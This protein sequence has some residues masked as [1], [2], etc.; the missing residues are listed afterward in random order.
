MINDD[1]LELSEK[2]FD[3]EKIRIIEKIVSRVN[4]AEKDFALNEL[5]EFVGMIPKRPLYYVSH[6]ILE[7]PEHGTRNIIRYL[8]D[9]IDQ[10]VRFTLEDKRFLSR[11]LRSPLGPNIKRLKKYIDNDLFEELSLFNKVYAQAKHEFNHHK[12]ESYFNYTDAIFMIYITKKISEKI[13]P[14]S[15]RARDYNN[16]GPVGYN[17]HPVE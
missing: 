17:Y 14:L 5:V 15:E 12:D 11:W 10:L 8:G 1:I 16:H 6:S 13:L 4:G 7:L 2:L 3:D 9:Y